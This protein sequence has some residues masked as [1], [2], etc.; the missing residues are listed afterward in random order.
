MTPNARRGIAIAVMQGL[1]VM[2]GAGCGERPKHPGDAAVVPL[3]TRWSPVSAVAIVQPG[4]TPAKVETTDGWIVVTPLNFSDEVRD[5]YPSQRM[6]VAPAQAQAWA[7]Q[8]RAVIS[9]RTATARNDTTPLPA[10]GRGAA[11]FEGRRIADGARPPRSRLTFRYCQGRQDW[12]DVD[13]ASLLRIV[14]IFERAARQASTSG[15]EPRAPTL[16]RPYFGSEVGCPAVPRHDNSRPVFPDVEAD[17]SRV[18]R[19]VGVRF[20]VDTSGRVEPHS[21]E[22]L[23]DTPDIF[24]NAARRTVAHWRFS[25]ALWAD[26]PVRQVVHVVLSFDPDAHADGEVM[27]ETLG[28]RIEPRVLFDPT[29]DGWI[30]VTHGSWEPDGALRGMREWFTPDSLRHW[31]QRV[32]RQLAEDS[33]RPQI[34]HPSGTPG[35]PGVGYGLGSGMLIAMYPGAV[36]ARDSASRPDTVLRLRADLVGCANVFYWGDRIDASLLDRVRR[37]VRTTQSMR[38]I[39]VPVVGGVYDAN[40]VACPAIIARAGIDDPRFPGAQ[41]HRLGPYPESMRAANARTEVLTSFVVDTLGR[42]EQGSLVVMN[43]SDQRAVAALQGGIRSFA[44]GPATRAGIRVRQRVIRTW[45]FAPPPR[46]ESDAAGLECPR[47][48]TTE[49]AP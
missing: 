20:V 21:V 29:P 42:V 15:T 7:L 10:L 36:F 9:A 11:W 12:Y 24:A 19:Q 43:G 25:P 49:L 8:T 16:D 23:P 3:Q 2:V 27:H 30:R 28:G 14:D 34:W 35:G 32:E 39:P 41:V 22:V 26:W 48:Y 17:D 1:L 46:C 13:D 44:F 5:H 6:F 31:L 37:S 4:P 18:P 47:T 38:G 33:I 45:V 40:E